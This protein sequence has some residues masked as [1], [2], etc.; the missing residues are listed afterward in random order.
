MGFN[1]GFKGLNYSY[2][3]VRNVY[4]TQQE[5]RVYTIKNEASMLYIDTALK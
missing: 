5:M 3:L 1:S 2:G 4:E